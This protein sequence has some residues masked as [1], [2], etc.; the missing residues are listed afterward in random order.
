MT[1][2]KLSI[3]T[4]LTLIITSSLFYSCS[5]EDSVGI[6]NEKVDFSLIKQN[7]NY[8]LILLM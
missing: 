3:L 1:K 8:A 2:L 4:V 5:N 7:I 6:E